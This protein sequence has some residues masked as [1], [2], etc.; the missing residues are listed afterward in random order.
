MLRLEQVLSQSHLSCL[1]ELL[2]SDEA[3]GLVFCF[4]VEARVMWQLWRFLD[5]YAI[6]Y[7]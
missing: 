6:K 3:S 1:I 4:E 5:H 7:S 2:V